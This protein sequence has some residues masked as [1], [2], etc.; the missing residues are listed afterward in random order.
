[1]A[2]RRLLVAVGGAIGTLL[3]A[4][5]TIP[6]L[7]SVPWDTLAVNLTGTALLGLLMGAAQVKP[8]VAASVPF[9]GVGILGS[10]TTFSALSVE[11]VNLIVNGDP[12]TAAAYITMSLVGGLGLGM[13]GLRVGRTLQ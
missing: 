6:E 3:R 5:V 4:V 13:L 1:M 8:A 11:M 9:I 12:L 10:L 7:A 2:R